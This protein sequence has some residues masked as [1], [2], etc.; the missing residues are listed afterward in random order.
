M[1]RFSFSSRVW[2]A[3]VGLGLTLSVWAEP[4]PFFRQFCFECHSEKKTKG[5][6]NIEQLAA[7]PSIGPHAD[8][9]EKVVEMLENGEMPP[10]EAKLQPDA[11][12]RKGAAAW[13]RSTLQAYERAHSG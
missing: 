3:A 5:H 7:Q 6:F 2:A 9:W 13:V 1:K 4:P 11:T 12:E 10:E 8:A